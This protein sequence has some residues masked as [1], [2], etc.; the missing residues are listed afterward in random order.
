MIRLGLG[1]LFC[2][3]S[4]MAWGMYAQLNSPP[5]AVGIL[6]GAAIM[7]ISVAII[8]SRRRHR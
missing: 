3:T 6:A 1:I 8:T 5:F 7:T 2:E 4:S